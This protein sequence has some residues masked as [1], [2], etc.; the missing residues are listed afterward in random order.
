M[1][2]TNWLILSRQIHMTEYSLVISIQY[3]SG[4]QASFCLKH[5]ELNKSILT[6]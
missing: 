6:E 3:S 4:F 1:M 2:H 5:M